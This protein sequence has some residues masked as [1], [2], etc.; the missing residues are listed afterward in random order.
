MSGILS[1]YLQDML[2]SFCVVMLACPLFDRVLRINRVK[3]TVLFYFI[4]AFVYAVTITF[5]GFVVDFTVYLFQNNNEANF[6][7]T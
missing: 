1:G 7:D 4:I 5:I 6:I 2:I 3:R